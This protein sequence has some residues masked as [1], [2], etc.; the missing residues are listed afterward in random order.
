MTGLQRAMLVGFASIDPA[1][2]GSDAAR[3]ATVKESVDRAGHWQEHSEWRISTSFDSS[4][5]RAEQGG[6]LRFRVRV[7]CDGQ[8]LTCLCPSIE[9]AFAFVSFYEALIVDQ[10]Y[11]VGPP[12][13]DAGL[14]WSK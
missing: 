5:T 14:P 7:E 4:I 11:S 6:A 3:L 13:A 8:V 12:W 2:S 1:F 10:F 9:K